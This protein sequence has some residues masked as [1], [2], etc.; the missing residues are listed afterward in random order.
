MQGKFSKDRKR[1]TFDYNGNII[2]LGNEI[3]PKKALMSNVGYNNE[4]YAE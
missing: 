3:A 2:N 4:R 1:I